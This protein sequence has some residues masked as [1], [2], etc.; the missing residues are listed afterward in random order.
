[1]GDRL[2]ASHV[3]GDT[4]IRAYASRFSS[5]EIGAAL[6]NTDTIATT[7]T[8]ATHH[9][10]PGHLFYWYT[11]HGGDDNGDFSGKVFVNERGPANPAS[12]AGPPNP[13]NPAVSSTSAGGPPDYATLKANAAPTSHGIRVTVPARGAVFLVIAK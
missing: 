5:G 6:V 4:C 9:F 11:L 1:M 13:A 7:V 10:K 12:P 3:G 2:L 8:I